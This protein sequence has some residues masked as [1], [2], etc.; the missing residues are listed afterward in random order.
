MAEPQ[1]SDTGERHDNAFAGLPQALQVAGQFVAPASL[2]AGLLFYW[3]FFHARGF[4]QYFGIDSSVLGLSTTDYVMRSADGLFVPL[5]AYGAV[6]LAIIWTWAVLPARIKNAQW[7]GRILATVSIV[8]IAL[9]LNGLSRLQFSTPLN[10]KPFWL[11]PTC[12]IA[13][14]L[15]A[16]VVV[17]HRRRSARA[18]GF[19]TRP[20]APF[21]WAVIVLLVGGSFFWFATDYSLRVGVGRAVA[22]ER[23]TL[24]T[25]PGITVFTEK[26]LGVTAAGVTVTRCAD[27]AAAYHYRYDGLVL[28]MTA[29]DN[30]VAVPRT[31]NHASGTA[32]VL[33]RD[34]P[35]AL[36]V[37]Y[38]APGVQNGYC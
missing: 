34:G 20:S 36:R 12:V 13:G 16:F 31:W 11:A 17:R 26:A 7:P 3:G 28:V 23:S 8:A 9:I 21:E 4:C 38:S 35:G 14:L 30:L 10:T 37:E 19:G 25:A 1:D 5:A 32:I 6:A 29:G 27:P 2:L 24:P 18:D 22:W 33:P 15:L